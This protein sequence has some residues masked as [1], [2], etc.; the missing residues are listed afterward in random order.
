MSLVVIDT[1]VWARVR[2]SAIAT[3]VAEAIAVNAVAMTEPLLLELLR[4]ARDEKELLELREEY[5][6]LHQIPFSAAIA[7]RSLEV[8]AALAR[9]DHHRAA[10]PVDLMVAAAAESV[11]AEVWHCDRDYELIAEVTGQAYRRFSATD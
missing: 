8:Q 4:S 7:A 9:R 1:S 2:S 10:S 6:A 3:A 5:A 11:G